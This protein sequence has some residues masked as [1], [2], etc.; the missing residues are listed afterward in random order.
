MALTISRRRKAASRT[1]PAKAFRYETRDIAAELEVAGWTP[2]TLAMAGPHR[3]KEALVAAATR[4]ETGTSQDLRR[5]IQP[6][7]ARALTYFDMV[8]E[9]SFS[10]EFYSRTLAK[11]RLFPAILDDNGEPQE[12]DD[13]TLVDL[14]N[15]V[16]DPSGGRSELQASYGR[17][18]FIIGEGY[19]TCTPDPDWGEVWEFLSPNELRVQPGGI[20]VR[21]R[22]PQIGTQEYINAPDDQLEPAAGLGTAPD[23]IIA[24][25]LWKK[26]PSYSWW[27][28]SSLRAVLDILEELLLLTMAVRSQATNRAANNGILLWPDEM[29]LPSLDTQGQEDPDTD[30]FFNEFA[31]SYLGPIVNPGSAAAS[32]PLLVRMAAALIP[33]NAGGPRMVKFDANDSYAEQG[34]RTE[35]IRRFAMGVDLPPEQ[36]LGMAD[37]NH[38]CVD[39]DTEILT[40]DRGWV[41]EHDLDLGDIVR[42]LNHEDG[43][44]EWE[45]VLDIY[46]ADVCDERMLSLEGRCHSSLTTMQHRWPVIAKGTGNRAWTLSGGLNTNHFIQTGAPGSDIPTEKK[47]SDE[48]V[49]LAAWIWTE[50][51][52]NHRP[53]RKNP[54]VTIYQSHTANPA[55]CSSIR[56]A[57]AGL[58]GD[59]H[60]GPMP[61]SRRGPLD[62]EPRWREIQREKG[63]TEFAL[64]VAAAAPLVALAPNRIIAREFIR[65]LTRDQLD[66][67]IETS[68]KADGSTMSSGGT[69]IV[70]QADGRRL[71]ALELAAILAGH[72]VNR[73]SQVV[74]GFHRHVNHCLSIHK[75]TTFGPKARHK[76]VV[77]YTGRIWCPVTG[78]STWLARRNGK[79]FYTGNSGWLIDEQSWKAHLMPVTQQM[80]NDFASAYLRPAARDAN[81]ANWQKVVIGYDAAEVI[82]HPDRGKDALSAYGDRAIGKEALRKYL[83][84][85][86]EDAPTEAELDEM[87]GVAVRDG[88]LARFGIP[89]IRGTGIEPK[90]GEVEGTS[91]T[92]TTAPTGAG[93]GA[94][95]EKGPPES[96][97]TVENTPITASAAR[98]LGA[99]D[100]T[101]ERCRELAGAR[102]K[103]RAQN[104]KCGDCLDRINGS[105]NA[106]VAS[107]L[108][109]MLDGLVSAADDG[110]F[111]RF[112]LVEGGAQAL[113]AASVRQGIDADLAA[114]LGAQIERHAALT[115]H[116]PDPGPLP[117]EL[118]TLIAQACRV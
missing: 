110:L 48:M 29:S 77:S 13:P 87:I 38:W 9:V 117:D 102:L 103:R 62:P 10:S 54:T 11:I 3:A 30:V 51:A 71:A 31:E 112:V 1:R 40:R 114:V 45:P 42:T 86:E 89:Q 66:L 115:L 70:F 5:L 105:E 20:Y 36:L 104:A 37:A 75:R 94:D 8:G 113:V 14:W 95:V 72:A 78:N 68:V 97:S 79:V 107:A 65:E 16:Q 53:G 58:Y 32:V 76:S 35:L 84:F 22:A 21:Y 50:G 92:V 55:H 57:L 18:M 25:R 116:L 46:R 106:L 52:I 60:E 108:G 15:R 69:R 7:Q 90:P 64:N 59:A 49:E 80:C 24:Y 109:D 56:D 27:A 111:P 85:L 4:I 44:A 34:I 96:G 118:Q 63:R 41:K 23:E 93:T 43:E 82:N 17:L 73:Y 98:V 83:G 12:T 2:A 81:V 39:S 88:S 28:H 26:H 91:G 19:L 100:V 101:V 67:F 61:S 6:W 99:A 33:E 74:E 47:W